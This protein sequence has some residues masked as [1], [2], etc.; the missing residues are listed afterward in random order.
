MIFIDYLVVL[1]VAALVL[2][3]WMRKRQVTLIFLA[4][5][6]LLAIWADIDYRWQGAPA[7][8]ASIIVLMCLG[9][10]RLFK[11][12]P[13][14][15][16]PFVSGTLITLLG[17]C[18]I[19]PIFLFPIPDLP[20]PDG[21]HA[22]GVRDFALT[23]DTRRGLL[24]AAEN[25]ARKLLVRVWYPAEDV[26]GHTRRPYFTPLETE[27]A[28]KGLGGAMGLPF[29]F[30]YLGHATTNSYVDA[31]LLHD[32][33]DLPTV[34]YSHGY[35][36]FAGQNTALMETLASHGYVAYSVQ[37]TGDASAAV[38]PDGSVLPPDPAL[39]EEMMAM[40]AE[41]E[42]SHIMTATFT[43]DTYDER[44]AALMANKARG[45]T[46]GVRVIVNS[47]TVWVDDRTFVH[48][49]LQAGD[50]PESVA[51]VVAASQFT[52]TGQIGMSYGGSTTGAV[53]VIDRRCAAGVNLDGGD[54]HYSPLNHQMSQPFLM[55]YSDVNM[56]ARSMGDYEQ[57]YPFND[58]SYE[59]HELAGLNP[60]IVRIAVREVAHLGVS[61]FTLFMAGIAKDT[62]L[63]SI[64]AEEII[65]IQNDFVRGFLDT[66]LK[67]IDAGFPQQQ[68]DQHTDWV[69]RQDMTPV[70]E[71]HMGNVQKDGTVRVVL[72]TDHGEI[73]IALYPERAP[74]SAA[75]FLAY[76]EGGHYDGTSFYR[77]TKQ[78]PDGSSIG[79]VQGGLLGAAIV[80]DISQEDVPPPPLPPIAHE[81]TDTTGI[82]NE[83]GTLAYGRLEPGTAGSEFFFN[84]N[85]N[86][87]LDTGQGGPERDGH[88][89][90][91]FGRVVRGMPVLDAIQNLSADRPTD[92]EIMQGQLLT[93]LVTINRAYVVKGD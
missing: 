78:K 60:N 57:G 86:N 8:V 28:G 37:H 13:S 12:K 14:E 3:W 93:D 4:L 46:Q 61:D 32:S 5:L 80:G 56:I 92:F 45:E 73:E 88:G 22:V 26:D 1:A 53:C 84:M 59:R 33:V 77:V 2:S 30:Q 70:R 50:V 89:Y 15:G 76:V 27:H 51:E 39:I 64:P 91:T 49:T 36:S 41:G 19:W 29:L 66:H 42:P 85:A 69:T 58:F 24:G 90:A 35:T 48:D 25:E 87:I 17:A 20:Q 79:V 82:P 40:T 74:I 81:T 54:Y 63:G 55:L 10:G 38:L 72:E 68:L 31:P 67:G 71:W 18:A 52:H 43:A 65:Q 9:L 44:L 23:D 21:P 83:R 75:N 11:R 16:T 6:I 62:L 7:G 34:I 47:P